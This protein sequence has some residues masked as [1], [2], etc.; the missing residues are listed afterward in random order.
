MAGHELG[1]QL[2]VA[3]DRPLHELREK[4]D[5]QEKTRKV[6]LSRVAAAVAVDE[7]AHSLKCIK[8][9]AKRHDQPQRRRRAGGPSPGKQRRKVGPIF[10]VA[11]HQKVHNQDTGQ[12][13]LFAAG[14]LGLD[15]LL[16]F[17]WQAGLFAAGGGI[18][19]QF[20]KAKP[21]A[22]DRQGRKKQKRKVLPAAGC[23]KHQTQPQQAEPLAGAQHGII[24]QKADRNQQNKA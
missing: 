24:Q 13:T 1:F 4:A 9:D 22:P 19:V 11:Q 6:F 8:A 23:K 15:G 18:G 5:E 10:K 12:H 21:T 14:G 17:F 2:A 7:V 16:F 20:G 3:V